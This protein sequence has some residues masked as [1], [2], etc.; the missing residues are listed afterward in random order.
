VNGDEIRVANWNLVKK[1]H[2]MKRLVWL[3]NIHV[4][5]VRVISKDVMQADVVEG[6]PNEVGVRVNEVN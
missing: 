2:R 4:L 1:R 5:G 3:T 6:N